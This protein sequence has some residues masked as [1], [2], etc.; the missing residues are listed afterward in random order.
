MLWLFDGL[1]VGWG[2]GAWWLQKLFLGEWVDSCGLG[3]EG[4]IRLLVLKDNL[5]TVRI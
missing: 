1:E 5:M 4:V 2:G 3:I